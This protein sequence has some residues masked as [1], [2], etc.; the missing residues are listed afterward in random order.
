M[1]R[2]RKPA[3]PGTRGQ[4]PNPFTEDLAG[5]RW[6]GTGAKWCRCEV[7]REDCPDRQGISSYGH[8]P[9]CARCQKPLIPAR[10]HYHLVQKTLTTRICGECWEKG[11]LPDEDQVLKFTFLMDPNCR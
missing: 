8:P 7:G 11:P 1:N 2:S 6:Q 9:S 4:D 5:N 10:T 3:V